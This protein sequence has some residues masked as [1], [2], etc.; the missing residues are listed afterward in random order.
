MGLGKMFDTTTI[1]FGFLALVLFLLLWG[2]DPALAWASAESGWQ[3][4]L[5]YSFLIIFS[6][7]IAAMLPA[8]IPAKI[9]THYLG[10]ASGWRGIV[11]ASLM[12]G[13]T[14]GAPYAVVP[15]IA[16]LMKQGMSF[17]PAVSM[18][19]AWG[20]WSLGRVPFQAAVLGTK[21]TFVQVV[22]SLPLPLVAGMLTELLVNLLHW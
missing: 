8:L 1:A 15:L 3:L 13:L 10:R 4:F 9:I 20:L 2:K 17:A 7:L 18:V 5:R 6:M 11:L 19:C 21:F 16:G 12:G 14:P 22:V